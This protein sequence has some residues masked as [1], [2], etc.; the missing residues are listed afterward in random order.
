[1]KTESE[2]ASAMPGSCNGFAHRSE[3]LAQTLG[4]LLLA[5][6]AITLG[7][8]V[9]LCYEFANAAL[10]GLTVYL[11]A[12]L[13]ATALLQPRYPTAAA[14]ALMS[15][16]AA[17]GLWA[18]IT[19][20]HP[21]LLGIAMLVP[22]VAGL[23][24]GA[25]SALITGTILAA[26]L[27]FG[28]T[29]YDGSAWTAYAVLAVGTVSW[30]GLR[31]WQEMLELS[32]LRGN[33]ARGLVEQL[34]DRQGEH[35]RAIRALDTAYRLLESTNHALDEARG[36]AEHLRELK[37]RFAAGLSH[38]LRT[39]LNI[40]LGFSDIIYRNPRLYGEDRWNDALRRDLAQIQRN[41]GYLSN[42]LDDILDLARLD[43]NAM[44]V[45]REYKDLTAVLEQAVRGVE[46][47][48]HDKE[49]TVERAWE[50]GLPLVYLDETRIHQV[51]YNLLSNAIRVT[52]RGRVVVSAR[53]DGD[54]VVVAVSD[55]GPGIPADALERIFDEYRQLDA[56]RVQGERGKGLGLAIARQL[57][58]MHGGRI[59]A[60][61]LDEGGAELAFSLPLD[62]AGRPLSPPV[63]AHPLP[64]P[65]P[66]MKPRVAALAH[67]A[68]A[69]SYLRRRLESYDLEPVRDVADL[70]ERWEEVQPL[71]LI[72]TV[73]PGASCA[74]PVPSLLEAIPCIRLTLPSPHKALD[75]AGFDAVLTKPVSSDSLLQAVQAALSPRVGRRVLI[76]DDDRGFVALLRRM[77]DVSGDEY[78]VC[79]AYN[80][81]DAIR[82]ARRERPDLVLLD[83]A[84]P[85]MNGLEVLESLRADPA[86]AG[87]RVVAITGAVSTGSESAEAGFAVVSG[88]E[89]PEAYL[90]SLLSTALSRPQT[91]TMPSNND[92]APA[93]AA[94]A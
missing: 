11:T 81:T 52:P 78:E 31:A 25:T 77:L 91:Q 1:M 46:S 22:M 86:T 58:R 33:E 63:V 79:V 4:S 94:T 28:P 67:N 66:R 74:G 92:S 27:L 18:G 83:L 3:L 60:R 55:D 73:A 75:A 7:L 47:V 93:E 57:V 42:L 8:W 16:L 30:V 88:E 50:P 69:F 48:A 41:A 24:F 26:A 61:N 20:A 34:R 85:D 6:A 19:L 5:F 2:S 14:V 37:S 80:G 43:A 29:A 72:E 17:G 39:P 32:C 54:R 64:V 90:L 10:L 62:G 15:G 65:Q 12:L 40:I 56:S 71:A 51:L 53:Q 45:R 21:A 84:M 87:M 68:S 9:Y 59:W 70:C 76:V 35:N 49:V 89:F 36:E 23:L 82:S 38:E 13:V 44:P